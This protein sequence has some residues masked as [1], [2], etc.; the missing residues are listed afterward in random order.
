MEEKRVLYCGID[1][2]KGRADA[3]VMTAGGRRLENPRLFMDT[4]EGRGAMAEW[5]KGW[6]KRTAAT[7]LEIGL[8]PTGGYEVHWVRSLR[9]ERWPTE[10]EVRLLPTTAVGA[11]R[12]ATGQRT[13]TDA[14]SAWSLAEFLRAFPGLQ[15]PGLTPEERSLRSWVR[16]TEG[17][18]KQ[19]RALS[20][21]LQQVLY[22]TMPFVL[23]YF[24]DCPQW[25]LRLL[26][27]YPTAAKLARA[28]GAGAIPRAPREKVEALQHCAR[29]QQAALPADGISA[30]NVQELAEDLLSLH[31]RMD[32][33]CRAIGE[34]VQEQQIGAEVVRWLLSVPRLGAYTAAVLYAEL[35][36]GG[37]RYGSPDALMKASGLDLIQY[38]S[39]DRQGALHLSKR[40]PAAVRR[41]LYLAAWRLSRHEPVFRDYYQRQLAR[42]GG[43]GNAAMV[44]VMKKLLRIL[45]KLV[46]DGVAFD[47]EH[48]ACWKARHAEVQPQPPQLQPA[49]R[50]ALQMNESQIAAAPL[51][52]RFRKK[53]KA[54]TGRKRAL[55][56]RSPVTAPPSPASDTALGQKLSYSKGVPNA[57]PTTEI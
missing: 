51:S 8:E 54:A 47:P 49:V 57:T 50:Q 1:V 20:N 18:R 35:F 44:A 25:L 5:L 32:Q 21:E 40:G 9:G 10:V 28:R 14:T 38:D 15:I 7:R 41:V 4:P 2:S 29:V 43:R 22:E 26:A 16:R 48:E 55:A 6:L 42:N 19:E 24:R 53:V 31:R 33:Q 30:R 36:T 46:T 27:E 3:A 34:F 13:G 37:R 56:P 45:W 52:Q 11:H 12:K 39:G 23:P 17:L